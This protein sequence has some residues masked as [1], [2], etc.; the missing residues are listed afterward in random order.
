MAR[1][2]RA[3]D[4]GD[5]RG[6]SLTEVAIL[7]SIRAGERFL[8]EQLDS[9]LDQRH[10][11]WIL[12]WRDDGSADG[13][14]RMLDDFA[15]RTGRCVP[16]PPM[17]PMGVARSFLALL[18]AARAAS[19]DFYAFADQDDVW[20]PCKL[21]VGVAGLSGVPADV[22]AMYCSGQ[23]LVD[24]KLRRIGRSPALRR[25]PGFPAALTQNIATGCTVM[26]NAAAADLVLAGGPPVGTLHDW[27]CYLVVSAAGGRVIADPRATVLY[28]QHGEN[29]V[30]APAGLL[31]RG[32]AALRRGRRPF[33]GNLRRQVE[34]LE[35]QAD[36]LVPAARHDL[37]VISAA[38]RGGWQLRLAALRLPG[39]R[40][41]G[42]QENFIFRLWFCLG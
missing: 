34:A 4:C 26:L 1:Q 22:P 6:R 40:R 13:S 35:G 32:L 2:R 37:A 21:A 18:A 9:L 17:A 36:L 10:R 28:R 30:G 38:L 5:R 20:L 8:A 27:W 25:V 33:M 39:F 11:H 23:V 12:Y 24:N 19:H 16:H 14:A 7:L 31:G 29:L 3:R 41:Q 15:D 42:W